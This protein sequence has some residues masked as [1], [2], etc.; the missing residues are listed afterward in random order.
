MEEYEQ[1]L[2]AITLAMGAAWASG[3]NLY[4]A[5]LT[6]G[7]LG[8]TGNMVLPPEFQ[9]LQH[10]MVLTA[11]GLMFAVEFFADKIPGV[12]TGWDAIHTFIRIPAGALLAAGAISEVNPDLAV[13]A[14]IVG[15]GIAA[16]SHVTKAGSRVL[17][18]ASPE[19]FSNWFASLTE[20]IAVMGGIWLALAHPYIFL[21][22]FLLFLVLMVWLLPR[23]WGGIKKVFSFFSRLGKGNSP[24]RDE[25]PPPPCCP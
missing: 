13:A 14:A 8:V 3:V 4:A 24:G 25:H 21:V 12:D 9:V 2:R 16:G 23:I 5:L 1:I 11:A 10:P 18:N 6:L 20:D 17:I 15:G 7:V 22:C 19:P